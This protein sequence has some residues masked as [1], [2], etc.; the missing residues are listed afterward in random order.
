MYKVLILSDA[1]NLQSGLARCAR[2]FVARFH[3]HPMYQVAQA[4]WHT[5]GH[6][7]E[8]P[9][10]I[11]P[12]A[13][14]SPD[15]HERIYSIIESQRPH[16]LVAIGDPFYFP[17]L[18]DIQKKCREEL[19]HRCDWI[20]WITIDGDP[21]HPQ[22]LDFLLPF[23]R[24]TYMSEFAKQQSDLAIQKSRD[25]VGG[26]VKQEE[27][28]GKQK[29]IRFDAYELDRLASATTMAPGVDMNT[30]HV[31]QTQPHWGGK[32][33]K[34]YSRDTKFVCLIV[35][36]NTSRKAVGQAIDAYREF[37]KGKEEEVALHIVTNP[38][39]PNGIPLGQVLSQEDRSDIVV[40]QN[41]PVGGPTDQDMNMLFN[42]AT[43]IFSA[44]SGEGYKLPIIEAMAARCLNIMPDYSS[45][46]EII[47]KNEERG[48]LIESPAECYWYGSFGYQKRV[49]PRNCMVDGLQRAW[50]LWKGNDKALGIKLDNAQMYAQA[51]TWDR[52]FDQ[53]RDEMRAS[54][55]SQG[56]DLIAV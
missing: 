15:E 51:L 55:D 40:H 56:L 30:F 1:I 54:Y 41:S 16:Y 27:V 26:Y 6:P 35:D 12:I 53:L 31:L 25:G 24:V 48:L 50:N 14:H 47:G 34:P 28:K 5:Q 11:Y 20:G 8:Y 22:Q 29:E 23:D 21:L 43:V 42:L 17:Y 18:R 45:P 7:H 13:R 36:Q 10:A 39:D 2:E 19:K 9:V 32:D 46:P 44:T 52:T 4:G 3:N 37:R 38:N 33:G 49:I